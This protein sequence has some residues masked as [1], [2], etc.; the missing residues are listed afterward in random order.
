VESTKGTCDDGWL[1]G[2]VHVGG[3]FSERITA[4]AF[5]SSSMLPITT[6]STHFPFADCIGMLGVRSS[7]RKKRVDRQRL[8]RKPVTRQHAFAPGPDSA[9]LVDD[10][11]SVSTTHASI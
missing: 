5:T 7:I 3:T 6:S 8:T 1:R 10:K 4:I 9:S 2:F 11:P